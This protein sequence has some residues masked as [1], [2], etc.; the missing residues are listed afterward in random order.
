MLFSD[1]VNSV[2]MSQYSSMILSEEAYYLRKL[3]LYKTWLATEINATDII[4]L[5][6]IN[7][8]HLNTNLK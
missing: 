4:K 3:N 7:L 6:Q 8:Q 5:S 2:S 1:A